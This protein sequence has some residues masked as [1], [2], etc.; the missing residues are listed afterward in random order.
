MG[1]EPERAGNALHSAISGP[2]EER[3]DPSGSSS[4]VPMDRKKEEPQRE[5]GH[6]REEIAG[7]RGTREMEL[8]EAQL[9]RSTRK[10]TKPVEEKEIQKKGLRNSSDVTD[11]PG[12]G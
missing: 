8:R 4:D 3:L 2:I 10:D 11:P 6:L 5:E 12:N 9:E 1:E 7:S